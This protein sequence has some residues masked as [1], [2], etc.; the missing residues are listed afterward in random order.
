MTDP[1][2]APEDTEQPDATADDQAPAE[3]PDE[4][5]DDADAQA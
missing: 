3:T 2:L 1:T 4:P 5:A